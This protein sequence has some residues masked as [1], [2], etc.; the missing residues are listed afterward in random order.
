MDS[1]LKFLLKLIVFGVLAITA[2]ILPFAWMDGTAKS[3]FLKQTQD[4][5]I[6]WYQATWLNVNTNQVN[7]R[8]DKK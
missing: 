4:I 6:P 7:L 5:D 8:Q 2:F 1:D 3:A